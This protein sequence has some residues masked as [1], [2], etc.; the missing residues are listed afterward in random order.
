MSVK[1][2][3]SNLKE[4]SL[5]N[6][7][8]IFNNYYGINL[9]CFIVYAGA[10]VALLCAL[11]LNNYISVFYSLLLVIAVNL[12]AL[13]QLIFS[14]DNVKTAFSHPFEIED[15]SFYLDETMFGLFSKLKKHG[16]NTENIILCS[17]SYSM[18]IVVALSLC[19]LQM[20]TALYFN[21]SSLVTLFICFF[22]GFSLFSFSKKINLLM[23]KTT[24]NNTL[25]NIITLGLIG[26]CSSLTLG[27]YFAYKPNSIIKL[28]QISFEFNV[29]NMIICLFAGV[30]C[31]LI[32]RSLYAR[33]F[34]NCTLN[35]LCGQTISTYLAIR[36]AIALTAIVLI[37]PFQ[38]YPRISENLMVDEF[39][40]NKMISKIENFNTLRVDILLCILLTIT[41]FLILKKLLT[42][43]RK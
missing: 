42:K 9:N 25:L 8:A 26:I 37:I 10:A 41:L 22:I 13:L 35:N 5:A 40:N 6:Y 33:M 20:T 12:L 24:N 38:V 39:L 7:L 15:E 43:L 31:S 27:K 11:A 28:F 36:S 3:T 4:N 32:H 19:F 29:P 18:V 1:S 21:L 23:L 2:T 16:I 14:H 34:E 17:I 30:F